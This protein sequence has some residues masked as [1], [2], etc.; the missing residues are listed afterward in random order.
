MLF[1]D[2]SVKKLYLNFA[3]NCIHPF[4]TLQG[5]G[6]RDAWVRGPSKFPVASLQWVWITADLLGSD[7]PSHCCASTARETGTSC[8]L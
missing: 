5:D 8:D 1:L 4:H 6:P 2:S 7:V 3:A